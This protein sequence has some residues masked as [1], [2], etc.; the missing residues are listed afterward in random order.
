MISRRSIL[1]DLN[2]TNQGQV[3]ELAG[4]VTVNYNNTQEQESK[5]TQNG[6]DAD[7]AQNEHPDSLVAQIA[8]QSGILI[9]VA[10]D[11]S[12]DKA[13]QRED[14]VENGQNDV[15]YVVLLLFLISEY[16]GCS[17]RNLQNEII[18]TVELHDKPPKYFL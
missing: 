9:L 13:E 11:Q 16:V 18:K 15:P 12:D 17:I 6:D 4:K 2:A 10:Q 5:L 7:E 8:E 1:D 3:E 14:V